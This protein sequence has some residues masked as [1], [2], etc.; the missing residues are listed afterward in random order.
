MN[1]AREIIVDLIPLVLAGEASPA[2]RALVEEY[3]RQD[4]ELAER[5]RILGAEGFAPTPAT[6]LPPELELRAL[7]RTRR[8]LAVQRWLFALGIAATAISLA[9]RIEFR[10]GRIVDFH[11]LLSEYPGLGLL[12]AVGLVLLIAYFTIR[13]R[14]RSSAR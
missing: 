3:L 8:L 14:L 12:L 1:T 10:H 6:D 13:R 5:V 9:L 11:F 4:P 7:R 2:S